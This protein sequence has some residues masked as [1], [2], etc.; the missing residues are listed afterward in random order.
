MIEGEVLPFLLNNSVA[1]GVLVWFMFRMEK[2]IN[3]NTKAVNEVKTAVAN[4]PNNK[5]S[6]T[7]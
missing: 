5:L 2:V 4:C 3:N 1:I 6:R 7:S